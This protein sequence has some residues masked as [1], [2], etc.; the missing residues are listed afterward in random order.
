RRSWTALR[1]CQERATDHCS[2]AQLL[3]AGFRVHSQSHKRLAQRLDEPPDDKDQIQK[4]SGL[5]SQ[6][7]KQTQ[8]GQPNKGYRRLHYLNKWS[9][10][11]VD[12]KRLEQSAEGQPQKYKAD[13][14]GR[15]PEMS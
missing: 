6:E 4:Q 1:K 9:G 5:A 14:G 12:A 8:R 15:T 10:R 11:V 7:Q 2:W 13:P 3:F